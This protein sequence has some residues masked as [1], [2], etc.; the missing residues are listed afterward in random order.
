MKLQLRI[1]ELEIKHYNT[2]TKTKHLFAV[3]DLDKAKEY[4]QNFVSLL[5]KNI[6]PKTKPANVFEGLFGNESVKI[7]KHLLE[8]ALET[9]P[10]LKTK[11]AIRERLKLLNSNLNDKTICQNCGFPLNHSKHRFR[12]YKFCYDCYKKGFTKK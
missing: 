10:N 5:P 9:R 7:A 2:E 11:L 4:P 8:R 3:I 12:S 1:T 6:N